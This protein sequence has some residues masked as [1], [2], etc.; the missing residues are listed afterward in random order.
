VRIEKIKVQLKKGGI[1]NEIM[2]RPG[3]FP[4]LMSDFFAR[5]LLGPNLFD[6]EF[7]FDLLPPRIGFN[8]PSANIIEE[9][10]DYLIELAA[11][12]LTKKDFKV[13]TKEGMITISAEKKE[14]KKEVNGGY[15]HQEYSYQSFS[16]SF[17]LPENSKEDMIDAKYENGILKI[18]VPKKEITP[19]KAKKE[20]SVS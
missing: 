13:E 15:S 10:K 1:M 12:G 16:R 20:I 3:L 4:N 14:E 19:L 8:I 18:T 7:D 5:P 6:V 11:P 17:N 9:E 2:R